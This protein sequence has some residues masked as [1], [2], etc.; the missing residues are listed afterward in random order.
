[1]VKIRSS[2]IPTCSLHLPSSLSPNTIWTKDMKHPIIIVN[3]Q[4]SEFVELGLSITDEFAYHLPCSYD[5]ETEK[6]T[7]QTKV[8]I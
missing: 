3:I 6:R 8:G 5:I 7:S 2:R 4:K 1:M